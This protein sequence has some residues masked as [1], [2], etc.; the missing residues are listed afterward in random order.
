MSNAMAS[1]P[2]KRIAMWSGPRNISTAMMRAF[3]NRPDCT[4]VDEPLYGYYL[5]TTGIEHP[6]GE[7]IMAAM[8][9]DWR[10]V[11]NTLVS[12]ITPGAVWYQ[13]HMTQH[14]LKEVDIAFTDQLANA[15]LIREPR[16]IIASYAKVRPDFSL[17][18]LGFPQQWDLFQRQADR[19]GTAPPVL[20]SRAVLADPQGQLTALCAALD[21]PFFS[22]MLNW[23]KGKRDSDGVWAPYWY[24]SVE[25][26]TGFAA[27]PADEIMPVLADKHRALWEQAELIYQRLLAFALRSD[28]AGEG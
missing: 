13:K 17:Q 2:I 3:E 24:E 28:N 20:E 14:L 25:A 4:V 6:G 15:F 27:P 16:R 9:C 7:A 26:S 12:G 23:P 10:S 18:E 5:K 1:Q 11:S 22:A 8:D 19:L 21:I